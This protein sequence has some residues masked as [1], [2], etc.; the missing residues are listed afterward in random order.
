M[1]VAEETKD[2]RHGVG[3]HGV[4]LVANVLGGLHVVHF[5]NGNELLAIAAEKTSELGAENNQVGI[6]LGASGLLLDGVDKGDKVKHTK[7]LD[8]LCRVL[9]TLVGNAHQQLGR[10]SPKSGVAL[11]LEHLRVKRQRLRGK[12]HGEVDPGGPSSQSTQGK[13]RDLEPLAVAAEGEAHTREPQEAVDGQ[14]LVT[15]GAHS[16]ADRSVTLV[17]LLGVYQ[18]TASILAGGSVVNLL[19]NFHEQVRHEQREVQVGGA[20]LGDKEVDE[21]VEE[22]GD[23]GG[24]DASE[25]LG[26]GQGKLVAKEGLAALT[27]PLDKLGLHKVEQRLVHALLGLGGDG[28]WP[29]D[30]SY[31]VMRLGAW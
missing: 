2:K 30:V 12:G 27:R 18:E 10:A 3:Q 4:G 9:D 1:A 5:G 23:E 31:G 15:S 14:T 22:G 17:E 21:G 29:G 26:N 19:G 25:E 28:L 11:L 6:V 20:V 8:F 13:V 16:V 24:V 7:D